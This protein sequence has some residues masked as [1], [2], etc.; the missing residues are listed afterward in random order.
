MYKIYNVGLRAAVCL[1][2]IFCRLKSL[3]T[4][5]NYPAA[6]QERVVIICLIIICHFT[7]CVYSIVVVFI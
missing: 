6:F 3:K 4:K 2:I 1:K 5:K 7:L